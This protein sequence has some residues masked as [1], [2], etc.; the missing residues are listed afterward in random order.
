MIHADK[1]GLRKMPKGHENSMSKLTE[2]QV[3]E[4]KFNRLGLYQTEIAKEFNIARQTVSK[5]LNGKSWSH[6]V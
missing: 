1:I 2:S 5:I 3:R 6:I 4:I